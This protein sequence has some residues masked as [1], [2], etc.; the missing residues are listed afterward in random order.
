MFHL[1]RWQLCKLL[2]Q[3]IFKRDFLAAARAL[4][5]VLFLAH[6][7]VQTVAESEGQP[8]LKPR[9]VYDPIASR[10]VK[11]ALAG[12]LVLASASSAWALGTVD[13]MDPI[14]KLGK[15]LTGGDGI[16]ISANTI[17]ASG[18]ANAFANYTTIGRVTETTFANH[19]SALG[20]A[21]YTDS[22]DYATFEQGVLAGTAL[23]PGGSGAALTGIFKPDSVEVYKNG[24]GDRY[25]SIEM[26]SKD[27]GYTSRIVE[28]AGGGLELESAKGI[29]IMAPTMRQMQTAPSDAWHMY[30]AVTH[31]IQ[32]PRLGVGSALQGFSQWLLAAGPTPTDVTTYGNGASWGILGSEINTFERNADNGYR[33]DTTGRWSTAM[34]IV[35]ESELDQFGV[36][37]QQGYNG[38]YGIR[39]SRSLGSDYA[40]YGGGGVGGLRQYP[41]A[42][43][44]VPLQF[45]TDCT[46]PTGTTILLKGGAST[47]TQANQT[48][49]AIGNHNV[50][51]NLSGAT[52]AGDAI[53]LTPTQ[54]IGDGTNHYTLADLVAGSEGM[55]NPM[56]AS[57]DIIYGAASGTPDRL[58]KG[59]DGQVLT[60]ASGLPSWAN[61]TSGAPVDPSYVTLGTN[62]TLTSER[63]LTGTSN[64]I[65]VTDG[66]AGTTVTLTTPQDLH[67]SSA[68]QVAGLGIGRTNLQGTGGLT[69]GGVAA[70]SIRLGSN[71]PS[72]S[73]SVYIQNSTDNIF[74]IN[75]HTTS[76]SSTIDIDPIPD[77]G[78]S[79]A[80]FRIFRNSATSGSAIFAIQ[81][82]NST[83]INSQI[84][85]R[86]DSFLN[87]NN[88]NVG[89]GA[90]TTPTE[91]L[92]VTGN[93][94]V[95]GT[96]TSGSIPSPGPIGG[97][98][99]A[100]ITGTTITATGKLSSLSTGETVKVN[101][102]CSTSINID[103]D[104]GG[105]H[106]LTLSGACAIGVTNLTAGESFTLKLTQSSTTAPTFTSAY[107]W[108]AGTAPTWSTSA[109]KYDVLSCYSD[110]GTTLLCNGMVD[111]R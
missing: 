95:S 78:T 51:M 1:T 46:T 38:N 60:L 20:T 26:H 62:G 79:A 63:V 5:S 54:T 77:D 32:F 30:P 21:A 67:T 102:T 66:G 18:T 86:G 59:T 53:R 110:D 111:V 44:H 87:A 36:G 93:V 101:G 107:K 70:P 81:L 103:P 52:I 47:S 58:A 80:A 24:S 75:K 14:T 10:M 97:T 45:E 98:T 99:P 16:I 73:N 57:G 61:S 83:T 2:I 91:K 22:T 4:L 3:I 49:K 106:T 89:I 17:S 23:Q 105:I 25:P 19:T 37:W 94:K 68:F 85:G 56:T 9:F 48:I 42:K 12:L 64:R 28:W 15:R 84:A 104:L 82:P 92:E 108:P 41:S 88:G 65:T 40:E 69:I 71:S 27:G 50:F 6:E 34:Q 39:F 100:A 74:N 11:C 90:S 31:G 72:V 29:K 13:V 55:S 7:T 33:E 96:I 109:T 35:P 76:G 43:W 8:Q